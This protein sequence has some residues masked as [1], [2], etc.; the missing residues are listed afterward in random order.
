MNQDST[1]GDPIT[2]LLYKYLEQDDLYITLLLFSCWVVSDSLWSHEFQASLP[3]TISQSLL[4][5]MSIELVMPCNHLILCQPLLSCLQSFP[6]SGFFFP[7]SQLFTYDGQ[8]VGVF[9][10]ASMK[11]QFPMNIQSWFPCSPSHS[12]ESS[13]APEFKSN[14]FSALSL[15]YG[16]TL[17]SIRDYWKNHSFDCTEPL[18]AKWCLCCFNMLFRFVIAFL[19]RSRH[20][21][22]LWLQSP[23]IVI[24]EHRKI[25]PVTVFYF[26]P[27][28]LP[29]SD[30]TG[31]HDLHSLNV[32]F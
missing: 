12:Q 4:K 17:T 29:W 6:A 16:P 13:P 27:I 30:E 7:V 23:S 20:F 3:F 22:I 26:F 24:L 19:P 18:L 2:G 28:Y 25:K 21:L 5:L 9:A 15:L 10:S 31:C 11:L 14:N 32:E 1:T 8:R